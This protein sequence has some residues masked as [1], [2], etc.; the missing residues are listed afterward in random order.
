MSCKNKIAHFQRM[1][2]LPKHQL[3]GTARLNTGGNVHLS[4]GC[5]LESM[6]TFIETNKMHNHAAWRVLAKWLKH[7]SKH[8]NKTVV[9]KR[10][11]WSYIKH[12]P[13]GE[14][15]NVEARTLTSRM[16]ISI[17]MCLAI[18]SYDEQAFDN[19][20]EENEKKIFIVKKS[21]LPVPSQ[22]MV[23]QARKL[24][25]FR[26]QRGYPGNASRPQRV[27]WP[28]TAWWRI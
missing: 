18:W 24:G 15:Q 4:N 11:V 7:S 8:S 27:R 2:H 17:A 22:G 1:R 19:M 21:L 3:H 23:E 14:P 25:H 5:S 26:P 28:R 13:P 6:D 9:K 12:T 20:S 10:L 16:F